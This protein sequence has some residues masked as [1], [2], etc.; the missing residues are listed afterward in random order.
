MVDRHQDAL[1][2]AAI[3][4]KISDMDF[5]IY[6]MDLNKN[7]PGG[8]NFGD[9]HVVLCMN[10]FHHLKNQR[11]LLE[12]IR[13]SQIAIFEINN[14]DRDKILN[15]FDVTKEIQ[16]PKANRAI[17]LCAPKGKII[18]TNESDYQ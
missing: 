10:V 6:K 3:F 15:Y 14:N 8:G 11:K 9:H 2:S 17:M 1:Y 16:S 7:Y 13:K 5:K 18:E 12:N 4:A